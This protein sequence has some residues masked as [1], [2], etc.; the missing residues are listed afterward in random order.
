MAISPGMRARDRKKGSGKRCERACE[1][2]DRQCERWSRKTDRDKHID[3]DK[4]RER[5]REQIIHP[6]LYAR[7]N[8]GRT[9]HTESID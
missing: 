9:E 7:D 2:K 4:G 6:H 3:K 8:N 5:L 1:K